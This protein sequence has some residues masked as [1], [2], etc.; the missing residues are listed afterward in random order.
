MQ[1]K[2]AAI[3]A[4][5]LL[6]DRY[7]GFCVSW[8]IV[9]RVGQGVPARGMAR[10]ALQAGRSTW[11]A[12]CKARQVHHRVCGM[13]VNSS[14][15]NHRPFLTG[16]KRPHLD[17]SFIRVLQAHC[18]DSGTWD[19][20]CPSGVLPE[21]SPHA[22]LAATPALRQM[23]AFAAGN[24]R[25]LG[26][27]VP[28]LGRQMRRPLEPSMPCQKCGM[29]PVAVPLTVLPLTMLSPKDNRLPPRLL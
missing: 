7:C 14:A 16:H 15:K 1:E 19:D 21:P 9:D 10:C 24:S 17:G 2:I 6:I 20:S 29:L 26:S 13:R 27:R 22:P 5:G 4:F 8:R 18:L 11:A 28:H 23:E 3:R 25:D 12:V